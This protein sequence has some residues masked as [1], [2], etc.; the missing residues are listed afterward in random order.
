MFDFKHKFKFLDIV[1]MLRRNAN[2]HSKPFFGYFIIFL[3]CL[4]FSVQKYNVKFKIKMLSNTAEVS[5][6]NTV[7]F[8]PN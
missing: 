5:Q 1:G 6:R 4:H 2:G 3:S 8:L 7:P